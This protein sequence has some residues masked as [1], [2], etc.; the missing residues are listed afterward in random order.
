MTITGEKKGIKY[1]FN[2]FRLES[3]LIANWKI[4]IDGETQ[5]GKRA[6][7]TKITK[8]DYGMEFNFFFLGKKRN[9]LRLEAADAEQVK[10]Y[11]SQL[12]QEKEART[13]QIVN[14]IINGTRSI[15]IR[16]SGSEYPHYSPW[17]DNLN[18][19]DVQD[20]M[21]RAVDNLY[22]ETGASGINVCD[23]IRQFLPSI[24]W[25]KDLPDTVFDIAFDKRTQE[26]HGYIPNIV[27]NFKMKLFD[28]LQKDMFR[29]KEA[30]AKQTKRDEE[31][32]KKAKETGEPQEIDRWMDDCNDP[33][34]DCSF[35]TIVEY[36][37]PDG[38]K[39]TQRYH[40]W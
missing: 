37:M 20:V 22:G 24:G 29:K 33:T 7:F 13:E 23:F 34:E 28:I 12:V 17:V 30:K 27:T 6:R 8:Q 40:N 21:E 39:K 14:E 31:A 38:T 32:I 15:D 3:E 2:N 10:A 26:Y 4:I 5:E 19:I 25:K 1:Q 9:G 18:D 11:R 36:V 35:D 16:I